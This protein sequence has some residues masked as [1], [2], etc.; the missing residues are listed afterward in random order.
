MS[1]VRGQPISTRAPERTRFCRSG[2]EPIAVKPAFT[3]TVCRRLQASLQ[4]A[5][6]STGSNEIFGALYLCHFSTASTST[7]EYFS[8]SGPSIS[9]ARQYTP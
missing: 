9:T 6:P 7:A 3:R 2:V 5:P 8:R 4:E 1:D